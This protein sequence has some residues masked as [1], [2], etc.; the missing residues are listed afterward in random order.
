MTENSNK[1][2]SKLFDIL[3][4]RVLSNM[5][6]PYNS[7]YVFKK[8]SD[9]LNSKNNKLSDKEAHALANCQ[10]GQY[11]GVPMALGLSFGKEGYDILRKN[12]WQK[13]E[14]T[15]KQILDDSNKDIQADYYGLMQGMLNPFGNC[16]EILDR[17]YL[18]DLNN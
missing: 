9:K 1:K 10:V 6:E 18:R 3:M 11:Y 7:I 15:P 5:S 16:E 14:L 13:S 8:N 12:T 17:K 2:E 4:D